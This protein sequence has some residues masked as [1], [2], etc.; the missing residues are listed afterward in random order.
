MSKRRTAAQIQRVLREVERDRVKG[1]TLGDICRKLGI[2]E[3]TDHRWKRI[4][5]L[6]ENR[7]HRFFSLC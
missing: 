6:E 5:D 4:F 3:N 7:G 2:S 1:L